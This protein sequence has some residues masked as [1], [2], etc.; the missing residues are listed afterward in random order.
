MFIDDST[1]ENNESSTEKIAEYLI[2]LNIGAN[3]K[4]DKLCDLA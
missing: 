2:E 1:A 3:E 4:V